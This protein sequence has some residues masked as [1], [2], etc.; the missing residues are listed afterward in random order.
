MLPV[1]AMFFLFQ[2]TLVEGITLGSI[3]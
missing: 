3:K 2:R 1:V